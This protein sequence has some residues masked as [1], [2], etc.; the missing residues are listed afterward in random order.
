MQCNPGVAIFDPLK[1]YCNFLNQSWRHNKAKLEE[2]GCYLERHERFKAL[3]EQIKKLMLTSE[4]SMK[5]KCIVIQMYY[6]LILT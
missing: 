3:R 6:Y 1:Y 5:K 2:K 4:I